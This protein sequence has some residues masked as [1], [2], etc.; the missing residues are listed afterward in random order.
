MP[1]RGAQVRFVARKGEGVERVMRELPQ[2][3]GVVGDV[4]KRAE[5]HPMA[6]QLV[7]LLG[8]VNVL[9]NNASDPGPAPLALPAGSVPFDE[10]AVGL[11]RF[12][13]EQSGAR[14]PDAH[15]AWGAPGA[16]GGA[17]RDGPWGCP[18]RA[19]SEPVQRPAAEAVRR[20][21]AVVFGAGHFRTRTE[22]RPLP[23]AMKPRDRLELGPLRAAVL[24]VLNHPRLLQVEFDGT[25]G[26][27]WEGLAL[28]GKPIQYAHV[29]APLA[30]W[31]T[32]TPIAGPPVAF[33]PDARGT[34]RRGGGRRSGARDAEARAGEP[35]ARGGCDPVGN[36]RAGD[37]SLRTVARVC[38]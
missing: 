17:C 20:F 12:G 19:A 4:S 18:M 10:G 35:A 23:P 22:D 11:V 25:A 8:G 16:D 9:V 26:E 29:P 5:I 38:L 36:A 6:L 34:A 31:D 13:G 37:K 2:A 24:G 28:H 1:G 33:E 30:M 7:G 27:V 32:W 3:R 14:S 15:L 21:S